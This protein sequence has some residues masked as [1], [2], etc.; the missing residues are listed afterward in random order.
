MW[1]GALLYWWFIALLSGLNP[2]IV[3]CLRYIRLEAGSVVVVV[4][5]GALGAVGAWGQMARG[6]EGKDRVVVMVVEVAGLG[7]DVGRDV[8]QMEGRRGNVRGGSG[9][10]RGEDGGR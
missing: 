6:G 10:R 2:S 1:V 9:G 8:K 4:G 7:T 5:R 3:G